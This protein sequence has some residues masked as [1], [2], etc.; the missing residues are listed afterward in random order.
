MTS[1]GGVASES[2]RNRSRVEARDARDRRALAGD[3]AAVVLRECVL[4]NF[5]KWS[6]TTTPERSVVP[7][8]ARLVRATFVPLP[9]PTT[10]P[11]RCRTLAPSCSRRQRSKLAESVDDEPNELVMASRDVRLDGA[12]DGSRGAG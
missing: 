10:E 7:P 5:L 6:E 4:E 12:A 8:R 3:E 2:P 9:G 1:V 11:P